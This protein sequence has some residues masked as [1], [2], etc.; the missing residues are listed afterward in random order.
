MTS[1]S[2]GTGRP[3]KDF[4]ASGKLNEKAD[5]PGCTP[6]L[7]ALALSPAGPETS[8]PEHK[9][10]RDEETTMDPQETQMLRIIDVCRRV[11]VSK[12]QI[13]RMVKD[14]GF[15]A[16]VQIS[17]R[18]NAWVSAEVEQWLQGRIRISRK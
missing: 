5:L 17:R 15:P 11:G 7:G 10:P 9:S 16:P 14:L 1:F 6:K 4:P 12:S 13:Y 8:M 18:T 3:G 2:P